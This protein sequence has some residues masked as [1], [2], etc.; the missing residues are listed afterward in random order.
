[1]KNAASCASAEP[2]LMGMSPRELSRP[3][4]LELGKTQIRDLEEEFVIT[5]N[6]GTGF[7]KGPVLQVIQ[8]YVE[9]P[10]AEC[11]VLAFDEKGLLDAAWFNLPADQFQVAAKA[12]TEAF[13]LVDMNSPIKGSESALFKFCDCEVALHSPLFSKEMTVG[14]RTIKFNNARMASAAE[15]Y[16]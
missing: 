3:F 8:R 7:T 9:E 2:V 5:C 1:M 14:Y 11:I 4:G 13:E 12:M 16:E 10:E 6:Q 15:S